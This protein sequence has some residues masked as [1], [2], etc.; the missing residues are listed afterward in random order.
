MTLCSPAPGSKT[1]GWNGPP[2]A[3]AKMAPN[4]CGTE[5]RIFTSAGLTSMKQ[6]GNWCYYL[7]DGLGST[8]AVVD[9]SGNSQK[10]YTY[11]VYGEV[12]GGSGSL[13]NEF[14]FAGQQTDGT[15]LQYLRARYYDPATRTLPSADPFTRSV[16]W[17]DS[18][19]AYAANNPTTHTD[20][21]GL[22]WGEGKVKAVRSGAAD[23]VRAA[24]KYI[25]D[26]ANAG[27]IL[28]TIGTIGVGLCVTGFASGPGCTIAA[29]AYIAG[30][31]YNAAWDGAA[32]LDG[33]INECQYAWRT[34][35]HFLP[36]EFVGG[37]FTVGSIVE[38]ICNPRSAAALGPEK[39]P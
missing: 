25:Q 24:T 3:L 15:G 27:T 17:I 26:P 35:S 4:V 36:D 33:E 8:M 34:A 20:P 13:A 11:D 19:T 30:A 39:N 5:R 38:D 12:T 32:D 28:E 9:S 14:D 16:T 2:C 37:S 31:I 18:P 7:A 1:R 22:Y 10:S 29:A 21:T 23:G 6:N